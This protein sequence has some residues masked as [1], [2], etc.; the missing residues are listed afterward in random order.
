MQ[1]NNNFPCFLK[2]NFLLK[3]SENCF[4][5][6]FS[7]S[8]DE[9]FVTTL[10]YEKQNTWYVSSATQQSVSLG[11]TNEKVV[12]SCL[13]SGSSCDYEGTLWATL[14]LQRKGKDISEFLPYLITFQDTNSKYFP[15]AFL[16][17]ITNEPSFHKKL[18]ERQSSTGFWEAEDSNRFFSSALALA[19]LQGTSAQNEI[20]KAKNYFISVIPQTS[21]YCWQNAIKETAF[22]LYAGWP[23]SPAATPTTT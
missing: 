16:Y 15:E 18:L 20:N 3:I 23:R 6:D 21:P 22:L 4:G 13:S 5:T 10:L 1:K 14:A 8:C 9:D 17:M 7:I 19:A 11:T 12:S 2:E